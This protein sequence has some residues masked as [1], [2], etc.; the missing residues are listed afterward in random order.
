MKKPIPAVNDLGR[1]SA[2]R[3]RA[4][5][6]WEFREMLR[7]NKLTQESVAY[8]LGA[9]N[10]ATVA[11]WL[12]PSRIIPRHVA[13]ALDAGLSDDAG[14]K[15]DCSTTLGLTWVQ[16]LALHDQARLKPG[17]PATVMAHSSYDVFLA[18]PMASTEGTVAYDAER[19]SALELKRALEVFC[20]MTVYYAGTDLRATR[21]FD[22]NDAAAEMNFRALSN[23]NYFVL[24]ITAD[25]TRPSSVFVEAGW[26]LAYQIPCLYLLPNPSVLPYCLRSLNQHDANDV[27]PPVR[28]Y[29]FTDYESATDF[30]ERQGQA[31]FGRLDQLRSRRPRP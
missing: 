7:R 26:A 4:Q 22:P 30:I 15:H 25:L 24:L 8:M 9:S 11:K 14:G 19:R 1:A 21:E 3:I 2:E 23:C 18:S 31:V 20:D 6:A 13:E 16:L 29:N 12:T 10:Q 17:A 5:I 28:F 27:L